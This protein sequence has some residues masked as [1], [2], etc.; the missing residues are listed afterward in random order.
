MV[1]PPAGAWIE[2]EWYYF[3]QYSVLVAPPA[4][5]WIETNRST[6]YQGIIKSRPLRARGLK[7]GDINT[8]AGDWWVA[9][10][11]GAWIETG[12]IHDLTAATRSRPLRAR[13]LKLL[14]FQS[15]ETNIFVA[16]PAGAW[17]ETYL[18]KITPAEKKVAP[19]AGAW[20]E[21]DMYLK[22]KHNIKSRPLRARGLKLNVKSLVLISVCRAPCGRVD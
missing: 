9:P 11:A 6:N 1:A 20:I 2:T 17:I 22:N 3:D 7:P 15:G 16:P 5:A 18:D 12:R 4:G 13:G 14:S 19:P 8:R 10:P 21:T